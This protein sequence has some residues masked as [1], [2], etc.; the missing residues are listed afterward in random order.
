MTG[1]VSLVGAGPGDPELLTLKAA[2]RLRRP[3]SCSTTRSS[4]RGS[5]ALARRAQRFFVGKRAGR[6]AITPGRDQPPDDPR[7]APRP[8]R[9]AAQGRRSVRVRPRR[10]GS[11]GARGRRRPVR[12]RARRHRARS[13]RRALAGIPVTHRGLASAFLVVSGHAETAFA[14][15]AR[16]LAP[17]SATLVVL[18]GLGRSRARSPRGCS[19]RGWS[20]RHAGGR[21]SS[22]RRGRRATRGAARSTTLGDGATPSTETICPGIDRHRRRSSRLPASR[23]R[24]TR[25][26]AMPR[27]DGVASSATR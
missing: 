21:S 7:G 20:P 16:S 12:G 10:R 9:R 22:T 3:T 14:P 23:R 8:A 4:T 27:T 15:V 24:G 11:A 19:T 5:L 13:R 1:L 25:R 17:D 6:H 2:R 18:M 26:R